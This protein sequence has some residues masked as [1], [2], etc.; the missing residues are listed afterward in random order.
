MTNEFSDTDFGLI[1]W[2]AVTGLV[3]GIVLAGAH[4]LHWI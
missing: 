3:A 1:G 2:L 4:A